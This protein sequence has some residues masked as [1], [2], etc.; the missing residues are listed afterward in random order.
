MS[1]DHVHSLKHFDLGLDRE[2]WLAQNK[3]AISR[4][5]QDSNM[6]GL[7]GQV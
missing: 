4:V 1:S 7:N 3:L 6:L 5:D 2:L